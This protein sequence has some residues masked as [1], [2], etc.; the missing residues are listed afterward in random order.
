MSLQIERH[1]ILDGRL[2][3]VFMEDAL[4]NKPPQHA[5]NFDIQEVRRMQSNRGIFDEN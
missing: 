3:N 2:R 5:D 4:S 1:Q